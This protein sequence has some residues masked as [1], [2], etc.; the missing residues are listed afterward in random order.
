MG[1]ILGCIFRVNVVAGEGGGKGG[2]N[3]RYSP[4]DLGTAGK[5]VGTDA[6]R[7]HLLVFCSVSWRFE[8]E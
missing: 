4:C 6:S 2:G 7:R 8:G 3:V 5:G 1:A